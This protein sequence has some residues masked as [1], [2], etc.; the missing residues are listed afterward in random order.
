MVYTSPESLL[1]A[2][3]YLVRFQFK[4]PKNIPSS[5][6]Y[7]GK[8]GE[9]CPKAKVKY[10]CKATLHCKHPINNMSYKQVIVV[11]QPPVLSPEDCLLKLTQ[12]VALMNCC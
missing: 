7:K 5:L 4:L 2:G 9:S 10:Y 11:R 8:D 1:A 6:Y 12:N 3:D